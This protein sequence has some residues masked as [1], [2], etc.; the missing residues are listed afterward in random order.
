MATE[1]VHPRGCECGRY[2]CDLRRKNAFVHSNATPVKAER[3]KTR[4]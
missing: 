3:A 4:N 2:A 1:S